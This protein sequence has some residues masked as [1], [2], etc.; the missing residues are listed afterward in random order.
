MTKAAVRNLS[1]AALDIQPGD[2]VYDIGAGTGSVAIAMARRACE[3][4]VY[5]IEKNAEAVSLLR[6]NR[7][8]LGAFN[9]KVI[10]S[11]APAG[12]DDLPAPDKVFVGGSS[13]KLMDI[14]AA[15]LAQKPG[16][17]IVVNA[18]TLET[19]HEAVNCFERWGIE[20]AVVCANIAKA[21]KIGGYHL[22][23]AQNPV[24]IITGEQ[25][26]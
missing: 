10:Q 20:S 2:V 12:M 26:G 19:V 3:G 24:Y 9:L 23:K 11:T 25:H 7:A 13:G 5:A 17:R 16:A 22:M 6:Q 14:F 1:L 18:I 21:E 15:V 8:R 4:F